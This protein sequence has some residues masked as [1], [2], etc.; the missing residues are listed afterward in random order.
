MNADRK[1]LPRFWYFPRGEK[2]VVVMTG[3]DH[4]TN[5]TTPAVR[6]VPCRQSQR[7]QRRRLGVRPRDVV[8]LSDHA[9]HERAGGGVCGRRLRDRRPHHDR[10]RGLHAGV[11]ADELH[12]RSRALC[13]QLPEPGCTTHQPHALHRVQRLRHA[14]AGGAGQRHPARHQL[15]LLA[16]VVGAESSRLHD[17]FGHADAVRAHRRHDDR[18]LPGGDADDRRVRSDVAVHDRHA[19]RPGAR[20]GGLLRVLR[21]QHAHRR[22]GRAKAPMPSSRR[23][24]PGRCRSSRRSSS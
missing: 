16:G 5:G 13:Q 1:P 6:R 11:A 22:G 15:L 7:L 18:R 12:R 21:R 2:A 20:T 8:H 23:R 9:D 3:D 14:A 4:G 19:A 24:S 17:R 10:L